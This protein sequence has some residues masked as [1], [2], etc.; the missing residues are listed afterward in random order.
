MNFRWLRLKSI[1]FIDGFIF[2][3]KKS[4]F[5]RCLTKYEYSFF[6]LKKVQ[7]ILAVKNIK[8]LGMVSAALVPGFFNPGIFKTTEKREVPDWGEKYQQ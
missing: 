7:F 3:M 4:N 5:Y 2:K 1:P 6:V 8:I